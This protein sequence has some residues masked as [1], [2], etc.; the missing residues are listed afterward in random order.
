MIVLSLI[1][2]A[3]TYLLVRYL[4]RSGQ[5]ENASPCGKCEC[6]KGAKPLS[7]LPNQRPKKSRE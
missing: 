1:G 4:R 7:A 3:L 2:L 5:G 6:S